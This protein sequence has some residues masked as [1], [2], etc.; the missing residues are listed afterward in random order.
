MTDGPA[1]RAPMR[2]RRD[3]VPTGAGVGRG[4][5]R[6]LCGIGGRLDPPPLDLAEAVEATALAYGERAADRLERFAGAPAGAV[7]WTRDPDDRY[8]R[9]SLDGRWRYDD[10]PAA[11]DADLV[12]V[13]PCRWVEVG[14]DRVPG[15]VLETFARGGRNFQRIRRLGDTQV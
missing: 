7:V 9:G 5:A 14:P 2:S 3:T 6:G 12:H 15:P 8:F 13:R 1:Y 11:Y 10:S 4:L